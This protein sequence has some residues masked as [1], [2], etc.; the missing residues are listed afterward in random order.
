M[1]EF[2]KKWCKKDEKGKEE[3][4]MFKVYE[5]EL[6]SCSRPGRKSCCIRP[7]DPDIPA[8]SCRDLRPR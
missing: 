5:T 4:K 3:N 7:D 6:A 1:F 2:I 8:G